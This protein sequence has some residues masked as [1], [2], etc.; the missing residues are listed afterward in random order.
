MAYMSQE[1]KSTKAPAIKALCKKYGFKHSLSI[2]NHSTIVLTISQGKYNLIEM[3]NEMAEKKY[4]IEWPNYHYTKSDYFEVQPYCR[5]WFNKELTEFFDEVFKI[6]NKGNHDNSDIMT[7]YF[8]VGWY[9]DVKIGK[10]DK[11]YK[12]ISE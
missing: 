2:H 6:L 7:D 12:Y 4:A 3:Y 9:V 1:R 5:K 10:W 11:P 8:D